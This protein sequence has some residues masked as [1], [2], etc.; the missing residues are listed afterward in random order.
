MIITI[1]GNKGSGKSSVAL[2][3]KE[4]YT[5]RRIA[6]IHFADPF[7]HLVQEMFGY[8]DE[9][10]WGPSSARDTRTGLFPDFTCRD[11]LI[12]VG[13]WGR[14]LDP[15]I[16]AKM[17]VRKAHEIHKENHLVIIPDCRKP[18]EAEAVR[19][20]GG[21]VVR[22]LGDPESAADYTHETETMVEKIRADVTI[23][24]VEDVG[25]LAEVVLAAL[26]P[27]MP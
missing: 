21:I 25:D 9:Q 2:A 18:N 27:C 10:L 24:F 3:I 4:I 7:K 23:P 5:D 17:A 22:K 20:A 16:W 6:I 8:T 14:S 11:V 13:T 1:A 15:D 19:A 12:S 26:G